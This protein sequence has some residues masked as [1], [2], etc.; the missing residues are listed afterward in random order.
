MI[1]EG[2]IGITARPSSRVLW[3]MGQHLGMAGMMQSMRQPF[4][5]VP[6]V[7][8]RGK[9]AADNAIA[10]TYTRTDH[11]NIRYFGK[12]DR[13]KIHEPKYAALAFQPDFVQH[14]DGVRFVYLRPEPFNSTD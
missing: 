2:E 4:I 13:L 3:A 1:V 14:G 12:A 7:N 10:H 8:T 11:Q 9:Q 5:H 6:V